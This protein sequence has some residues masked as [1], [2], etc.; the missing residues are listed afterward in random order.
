MF[1]L[2]NIRLSLI[3]QQD[4][5]NSSFEKTLLFELLAVC[6]TDTA[7]DAFVIKFRHGYYIFK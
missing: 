6:G 7:Q 4:N 2:P 1:V 5:V 3:Y